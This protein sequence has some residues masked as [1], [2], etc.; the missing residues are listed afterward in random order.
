MLA[1]MQITGLDVNRMGVKKI[2]QRPAMKQ[3]G[4]KA[5]SKLEKSWPQS[6]VIQVSVRHYEGTTADT[7][8]RGKS[9]FRGEVAGKYRAIIQGGLLFLPPPNFPMCQNGEKQQS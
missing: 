8:P 9:D 2:I 6:A 5:F 7:P 1:V 3:D 4:K